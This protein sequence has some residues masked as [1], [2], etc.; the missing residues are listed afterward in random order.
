MLDQDNNLYLISLNILISY[1][2]EEYYREKFDIDHFW[3]LKAE[4]S[5]SSSDNGALFRL[6][7]LFSTVAEHQT[8]KP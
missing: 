1:L 5:R 2:L 6:G 8:A 4:S 3:E 7:V